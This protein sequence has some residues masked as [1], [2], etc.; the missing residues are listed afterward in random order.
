VRVGSSFHFAINRA[1]SRNSTVGPVA[2][3]ADPNID[4]LPATGAAGRDAVTTGRVGVNTGRWAADTAVGN[5]GL[6]NKPAPGDCPG[7]A[8]PAVG[9]VGIGTSSSGGGSGAPA[10]LRCASTSTMSA[11]IASVFQV[12][13]L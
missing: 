4:A 8:V 2:P 5:V 11:F 9:N 10:S 1:I 3:P 12:P 13:I 6:G 7:I